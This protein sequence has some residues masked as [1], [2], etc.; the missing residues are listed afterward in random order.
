MH[1]FLTQSLENNAWGV[2]NRL[3]IQQLFEQENEKA[4]FQKV[5]ACFNGHNH[6]DY[7]R[8]VN[9]IYYID[10]NRH[11]LPVAWSRFR[12]KDSLPSP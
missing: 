9:G 5:I 10:M 3:R 6:I 11:V 7:Y 8:R 4:G 12:A 2:K 1:H